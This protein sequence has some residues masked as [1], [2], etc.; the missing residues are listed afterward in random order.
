M[1]FL[2]GIVMGNIN[3]IIELNKKDAFG[4][5]FWGTLGFCT[6]LTL[7]GG[8]SYAATVGLSKKENKT[9]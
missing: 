1:I 2:G 3:L 9:F 8:I 6:A 4:V 5:C 7:V